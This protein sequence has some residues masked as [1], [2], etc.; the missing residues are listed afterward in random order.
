MGLI[1][2]LFS[3]VKEKH[4]CLSNKT[5]VKMREAVYVQGKVSVQYNACVKDQ[6]V[7]IYYYLFCIQPQGG[8]G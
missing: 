4:V 5:H 3:V 7:C 1:G 2:L 8:P 6:C